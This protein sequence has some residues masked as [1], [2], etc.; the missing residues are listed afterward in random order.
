MFFVQGTDVKG[1]LHTGDEELARTVVQFGQKNAVLAN[2]Y[3]PN[4]TVLHR[5]NT[6][7]V[8]AFIGKQV[9]IGQRV[10][11]TLDSAIE[12]PPLPTDLDNEERTSHASHSD[13]QNHGRVRN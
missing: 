8:G 5:A 4:G 11:L 10:E 3:A 7:A 12:P 1:R 9:H 6:V 2:V 13:S